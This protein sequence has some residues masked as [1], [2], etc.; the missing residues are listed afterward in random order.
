VHQ[1]LF[2]SL[3]L[4][5]LQGNAQVQGKSGG[6]SQLKIKDL[7][8]YKK[9]EICVSYTHIARKTLD[10]MGIP[11]ILALGSEEC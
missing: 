1:G 11:V 5:E 9:H 2:A 10:S 7:M 4:A 3:L 6:S 8:Q